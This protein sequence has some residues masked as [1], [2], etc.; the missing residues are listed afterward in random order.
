VSALANVTATSTQLRFSRFFTLQAD[1]VTGVSLERT[2]RRRHHCHAT[3]RADRWPFVIH[4]WSMGA[5]KELERDAVRSRSA[6]QRHCTGTA[7]VDGDRALR[8]ASVYRYLG[9]SSR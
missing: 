4:T 1:P 7:L 6:E 2:K 9:V 8:P 3:R 5:M